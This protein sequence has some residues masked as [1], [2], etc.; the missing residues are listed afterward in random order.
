MYEP[1]G[2]QL[3]IATAGHLP[4]LL[5][6][7]GQPTRYLEL[8]PGLPLGVDGGPFTETVLHLSPRTT[9]LLCTDGLVE[10]R[11]QDVGTGLDR[12]AAVL[13]SVA[14]PPDQVCD[15]VLQELGIDAE[16]ADDDIALLV[17]T[18]TG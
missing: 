11:E 13:D 4:P 15:H 7:P 12:L 8:E 17:A 1:D 3:T 10:S 9:L 2:R 16:A 5:T 14:L 6:G 18:T